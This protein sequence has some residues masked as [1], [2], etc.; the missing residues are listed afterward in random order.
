M[1]TVLLLGHTP[2]P[3]ENRNKM[4]GPGIRTWQF[5]KPLFD[6]GHKV[7]VVGSRIPFVYDSDAPPLSVTCQ[8]GITV[9]SLDQHLFETGS[10]VQ[11]LVDQ[12]RPD[13]IVGAT[14]FP[15]RVACEL[16]TELPV[17]VDFFGD[18]MAEAQAKAFTYCDDAYIE[19]FKRF[20]EIAISR[21]DVFS[22]VSEPQKHALIGQLGLLGRLNQYTHG[23]P[24]VHSIPCAIEPKP[25]REHRSLLRG[26][27]IDHD[28][29]AV[30]WSGGYNTWTDVDTLFHGLEAA[31][32]QDARIRFVSTGGQI[33]G[34]DE[35]TYPRFLAMIERSRFRDR[36]IMLGWVPSADVLDYSLACDVGINID[37][38]NYEALLG[39]RNRIIQWMD[40]GIPVLTTETSE[41]T[42]LLRTE[43]LGF[44]FEHG[45]GRSLAKGILDLLNNPE[46]RRERVKRA[47]DYVRCHWTFEATTRPLREWV[48]HPVSSPDRRVQQLTRLSHAIA[49]SSREA[50]GPES[51]PSTSVPGK[52]ASQ[53]E[54]SPMSPIQQGWLSRQMHRRVPLIAIGATNSMMRFCYKLKASR[55]RN[56]APRAA[57]VRTDLSPSSLSV[58]E[59]F[60]IPIVLQN[61]GASAWFPP[62]TSEVTSNLSYHW[63]TLGGRPVVFDGLRTPMPG[64][65]QAGASI[66]LM[67]LVRSPGHPGTYIL[68]WDM[69]AEGIAWFRY[70]DGNPS[71]RL[72]VK[73]QGHNRKHS[74]SAGPS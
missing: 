71:L 22:S 61:R 1:T 36:F 9:H 34:H 65:I 8:E 33:D 26:V 38:R 13:C 5:A 4:F 74:F 70:D 47:T 17:W 60:T 62:A 44:V 52:M 15:S 12:Y 7:I 73:V 21:G 42:S 66:S 30:L 18:P 20:S 31:M 41:I 56:Q 2:L 46:E 32:S 40:L 55:R 49:N 57:Y 67:A 37:A 64:V 14:A 16:R 43:R 48:T 23:T 6:D 3:F 11:N 50:V 10:Y 69:V 25:C 24:L 27:R 45:N 35:V 58:D 63:L 19:H 53:T 51:E 68:E 29:F 59:L 72:I 54:A 39:S 28:D